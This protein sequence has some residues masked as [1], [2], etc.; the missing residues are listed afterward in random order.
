MQAV[1]LLG[2]VIALLIG[3]KLLIALRSVLT[4][5]ARSF[6]GAARV[7]ASTLAEIVWS[8]M[9]APVTLMFQ[10]RS[11]WQVLWGAD[12]GWPSADRE[13]EAVGMRE[14][15]AS[16]WWIVLTGLLL[17]AGTAV[18]A[19]ELFYWFIPIALPLTAAPWLISASSR[20]TGGAR[21][22]SWGLFFTPAESD[23]PDVVRMQ[24]AV[25]AGWRGPAPETLAETVSLNFPVQP[26]AE[27]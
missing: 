3:P 17:L 25:L 2:G 9:L 5:E 13:A 19:P 11:V 22:R 18:L 23:L 27:H 14:A 21:A 1:T 24:E 8:S 26:V 15:W 12:S 4:G 10:S 20:P 16:A 7:V 6:G